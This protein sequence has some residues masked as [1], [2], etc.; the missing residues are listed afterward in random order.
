MLL[1]IGVLM[2]F[3]TPA[4]AA[5]VA[6]WALDEQTGQMAA[7]STGNGHHGWLGERPQPDGHDP[8]WVS[9]RFGSALRFDA[10]QDLY[11]SIASGPALVR[12]RITVEA[13]V[14]RLGTPGRWRYVFASGATECHAAPY[15]MYSGFT[16]GLAFY[17][18]DRA[19]Y[20]VSPEAAPSTV[21]DG[22]WHHTAGTYDGQSV[23]LYVDGTQIGNGT[24]TM[25]TIGSGAA[26]APALI[27]TYR[28]SCSLHFT[29]DVD[30]VVVHGQS[31]SPEQIALAASRA[32]EAPPQ[33]PPVSGPPAGGEPR[34][35]GGS[36]PPPPS[37][38]TVRGRP[39]TITA[40][41][42]TSV[43]VMVRRRGRPAAG[44]RVTIRGLGVT[45]TVRTG[46]RGRARLVVRA[47]RHGRLR[48][49]ALGYSKRCPSGVVTVT[50]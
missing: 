5:P 13:W 50:R 8:A 42:R 18:S 14:R 29:G 43:T 9:G 21:W 49:K 36:N 38:P 7:D 23:R 35:P 26:T 24:P 46:R 20:V 45:R 27:G 33:D 12:P 34:G 28:G 30:E 1:L 4:V 47:S 31:L 3:T 48:L 15:G 22:A 16:A 17:V 39:R 11:V 32:G 44:R 10:H 37:C 6:H 40:G 41:T 25:L 2:A 19:G